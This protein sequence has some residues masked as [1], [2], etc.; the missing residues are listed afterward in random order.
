LEITNNTVQS[1]D[2]VSKASNIAEKVE[3][4]K[5]LIKQS[6]YVEILDSTRYVNLIHQKEPWF[7]LEV[8]NMWNFKAKPIC[9]SYVGKT[10]ISYILNKNT[11][12][13]NNSYNST[14]ISKL[15]TEMKQT[16]VKNGYTL[17]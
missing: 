2:W 3:E 8:V 1:K 4:L 9:F 12:I 6:L 13:N 5:V 11:K 17:K 10:L 14:I 7:Q 16:L 15:S